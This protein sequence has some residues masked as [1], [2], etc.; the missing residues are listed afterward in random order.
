MYSL[1]EERL[2]ACLPALANVLPYQ[3]KWS[4]LSDYLRPPETWVKCLAHHAKCSGGRLSNIQLSVLLCL[5][6]ALLAVRPSVRITLLRFPYWHCGKVQ[7]PGAENEWVFFVCVLFLQF[8]T[9]VL[10]LY[11]SALTNCRNFLVSP[12][13]F[14][15]TRHGG[16]VKAQTDLIHVRVTASQSRHRPA[17]C[18]RQ[19]EEIQTL[20]VVHRGVVPLPVGS[21]RAGC[22]EGIH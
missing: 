22:D 9:P 21:V 15:E 14:G 7:E 4:R 5:T 19:S 3:Q 1:Q 17:R 13:L 18:W 8:L 11:Q 12:A 6:W 16:N 10:S 20:A 2:P